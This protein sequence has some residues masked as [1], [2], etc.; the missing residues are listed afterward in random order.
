MEGN[1]TCLNIL[2]E[3]YADVMSDLNELNIC[4]DDFQS[5]YV[6]SLKR[7]DQMREVFVKITSGMTRTKNN[8][9]RHFTRLSESLKRVNELI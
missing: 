4:L 5:K 7:N 1:P 3:L 8:F 9:Q 6:Q 2:N